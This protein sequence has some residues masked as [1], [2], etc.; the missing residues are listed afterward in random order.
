M[1]TNLYIVAYCVRGS[2][3]SSVFYA[4]CK[5]TME[6]DGIFIYLFIFRILRKKSQSF[7]SQ[8]SDFFFL[9]FQNFY[10]ILRIIR[11]KSEF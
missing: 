11:K 2:V 6:A 9:E 8:N 1:K 10:I 5:K 7:F 3:I 4:G